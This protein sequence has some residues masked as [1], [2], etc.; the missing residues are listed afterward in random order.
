MKKAI[1]AFLLSTTC[2][3][4]FAGTIECVSLVKNN[5]IELEL[6]KSEGFDNCFSLSNV[7]QNT[8]VQFVAFSKDNVQNKISLF[9]FNAGGASSYI[10]EY[11]SDVGAANAFSTNT[12]N[13]NLSFRITPTSHLSTDKN[14]SITYLDVDNV[15]QVLIDFDDIPSASSTPPPNTGGCRYTGGVRICYDEK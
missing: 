5:T 7:S 3:S 8:P 6:D 15:T 1:L 14:A 9:D 11:H 2:I 13:R 4:A 12:T 10:A